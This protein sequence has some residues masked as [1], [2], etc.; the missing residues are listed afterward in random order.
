MVAAGPLKPDVQACAGLQWLRRLRCN[1]WNDAPAC[2]VTVAVRGPKPTTGKAF[3]SLSIYLY[4]S[5]SLSLLPLSQEGRLSPAR[6]RRTG[7][8]CTYIPHTHTHLGIHLAATHPVLDQPGW[9]S[10]VEDQLP[11]VPR[12]IRSQVFLF[13]LL[14]FELYKAAPTITHARMTCTC[15]VTDCTT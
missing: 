15:M 1:A 14:L 13:A 2:L 6:Y 10:S 3:D 7:N 4:P 8:F 12:P 5:L 11:R 9:T